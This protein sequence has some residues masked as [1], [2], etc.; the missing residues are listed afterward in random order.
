MKNQ[1]FGIP[2]FTQISNCETEQAS[3]FPPGGMGKGP[4]LLIAATIFA[5]LADTS[6]ISLQMNSRAK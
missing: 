5:E 2:F 6:A 3:S 1:L 4:V